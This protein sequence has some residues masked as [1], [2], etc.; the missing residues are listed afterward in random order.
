VRVSTFDYRTQENQEILATFG[1]TSGVLTGTG[2]AVDVVD[3]IADAIAGQEAISGNTPT[4]V[5]ANPT[6]VATIRMAKASTA[7]TYPIDPLTSGST[8][9]HGVQVISTPGTAP[10]TAWVVSGPVSWSTAA[11]S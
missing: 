4:A 1:S 8:S 7:G 2:E 11:D 5:I 6:T 3:L 10:G 9:I